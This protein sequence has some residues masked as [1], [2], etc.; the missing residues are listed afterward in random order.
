MAGWSIEATGLGHRFTDRWVFVG[1]HFQI[2]AGARVALTGMNGSGKSTLGR[3]IAGHLVP[4]DGSCCWNA[5]HTSGSEVLLHTLLVG[6]GSALPPHLTAR[7]ALKWHATFRS[8]PEPAAVTRTW[9]DAGIGGFLDA[10]LR[11]LSTGMRARIHLGLAWGT[12]SPLV[13]L[14]EPA[15]NLDASGKVWYRSLLDRWAER[16]TVVVCTNAPEEECPQA[17]LRL[18]LGE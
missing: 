18:H 11:T 4:S 16:A 1:Q 2:P 3:V 12:A 17:D 15:A 13:V 6:T 10:P 8:V 14:D 9:E 7:E 5:V